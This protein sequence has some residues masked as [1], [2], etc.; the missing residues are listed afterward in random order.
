MAFSAKF[1]ALGQQMRL[2]NTAGLLNFRPE[3]GVAVVLI[4]EGRLDGTIGQ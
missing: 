2:A 4:Q 3:I 1:L